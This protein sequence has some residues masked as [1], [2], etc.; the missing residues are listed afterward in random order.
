MF[1]FLSVMFPTPWHRRVGLGFLLSFASR[2]T[3]TLCMRLKH[4]CSW[5]LIEHSCDEDGEHGKPCW[6]NYLPKT[7]LQLPHLPAGINYLHYLLSGSAVGAAQQCQLTIKAWCHC[8]FV[9]NPFWFVAVTMSENV[10]MLIFLTVA[11]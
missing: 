11:Y 5:T 3:H 9:A 2:K 6:C 8:T 10:Y 4:L 1:S 7:E